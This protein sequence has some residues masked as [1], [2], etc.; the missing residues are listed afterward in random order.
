M[1]LPCPDLS[2]PAMGLARPG[3]GESSSGEAAGPELRLDSLPVPPGE[4]QDAKP[5]F[6]T[7]EQGTTGSNDLPGQQHILT[8][9]NPRP[10][11]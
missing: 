1:D 9:A 6:G 3:P 10:S 7:R 4:G 2:G 11:R 8:A 5:A